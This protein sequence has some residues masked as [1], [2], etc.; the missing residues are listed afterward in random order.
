MLPTNVNNG[1]LW[2][3]GLWI[4]LVFILHVCV[5][6]VCILSAIRRHY[7]HI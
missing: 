4:G 3:I 1:C 5:C 6:V 2:V 7:F